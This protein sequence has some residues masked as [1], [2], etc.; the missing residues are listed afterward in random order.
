MRT[1]ENNR[2]RRKTMRLVN[3]S[4]QDKIAADL[5]AGYNKLK[6]LAPPVPSPLPPLNPDMPE[7]PR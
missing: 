2:L 1:E 3:K 6:P 7:R 4:F 5:E